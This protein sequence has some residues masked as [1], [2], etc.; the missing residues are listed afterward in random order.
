MFR[1]FVF[2]PAQHYP[3]TLPLLAA[4]HTAL[5]AAKGLGRSTSQFATFSA[6][7]INRDNEMSA[8]RFHNRT[9]PPTDC[10]AKVHKITYI[11]KF[12]RTFL[13]SKN[14]PPLK[15]PQFIDF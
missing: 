14:P 4:K 1:F 9:I 8:V 10:N 3:H 12:A 6:L 5:H 7:R 13:V 11:A 2:I 15:I